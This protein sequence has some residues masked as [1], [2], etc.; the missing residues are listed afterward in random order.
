[1]AVTVALLICLFSAGMTP[2]LVLTRPHLIFG[3]LLSSRAAPAETA[4][5]PALFTIY[6]RNLPPAMRTEPASLQFYN[7]SQ[8]NLPPDASWLSIDT[9]LRDRL[10]PLEDLILGGHPGP[11]GLSSMAAVLLG[12]LL[13]LFRGGADWRVPLLT[14]GSAFAAFLCLR[15]PLVITDSGPIFRY[16]AF[17]PPSEGGAGL[18]TMT[19]YALYQIAAGPLVFTSLFLATSA[20]SCPTSRRGRVIYA[21]LL[22]VLSAVLQT[23]FTVAVGPL[24]ALLVLSLVAPVIDRVVRP[25][26]LL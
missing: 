12:G 21:V 15:V 5:D 26:P 3:D 23:Y 10:P 22:G 11:L 18:S 4:Q 16:F 9:F 1:V 7:F 24:G 13:L 8:G 2:S 20:A 14:L 17:R 25:K 19:V 6:P